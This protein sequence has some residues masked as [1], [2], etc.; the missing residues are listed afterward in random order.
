MGGPRP[1]LY[2]ELVSEP[3]YSLPRTGPLRLY[4]SPLC[5]YCYRVMLA[6][7][8]LRIPDHALQTLNVV[9]RPELRQEIAAATGR[10]TVPALHIDS[11]DDSPGHWLFESRAIVAYLRARFGSD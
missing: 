9:G 8:L 1:P 4:T 3:W 10:R 2:N 6:V 11:Q 7:T 5:G